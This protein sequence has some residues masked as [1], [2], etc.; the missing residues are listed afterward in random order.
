MKKKFLFH[1]AHPVDVFFL[2]LMKII[3]FQPQIPQNTG[4]IVR[5]CAVTGCELILVRPIGFST[6]NRMLRRAGLDYWEDV[7]ISFVDHI[8]D[9]LNKNS[10]PVYFFSSKAKKIYSEA[11][12]VKDSIL[13]FGSETTGL[14][15]ELWEKWP[16]NFFTLPMK[17][18][19]RCLNLSN[20]V[21]IVIYE[22]WRQQGFST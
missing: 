3:L 22:A 11:V 16:E 20:A 2:S 9:F 14:P 15:Q 4:N 12:Y 7:D 13:I 8:G 21:S 19:S 6:S 10:A 17:Q 1:P 18:N 5:T